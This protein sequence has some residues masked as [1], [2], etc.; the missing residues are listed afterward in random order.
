[1]YQ[2]ACSQ[3]MTGGKSLSN[4][5]PRAERTPEAVAVSVYKGTG[6]GEMLLFSTFTGPG[7]KNVPCTL[8]TNLA[9]SGH[10]GFPFLMQIITPLRSR[11]IFALWIVWLALEFDF[12]SSRE[13]CVINEVIFT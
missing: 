7:A 10:K 3:T 8:E 5:L 12:E 6:A 2:S 1:M 11:R 4:M 9:R 13:I